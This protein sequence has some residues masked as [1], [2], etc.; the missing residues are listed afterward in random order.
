[1]DTCI[2]WHGTF[3]RRIIK[4]RN[5]YVA[6]AINPDVVV[7]VGEKLN[8]RCQQNFNSK[9]TWYKND[10]TLHKS[11]SRIRITKQFLKFKS[12]EMEDTAVYSCK[13]ESN[14][15]IHW[16]NVTVRVENLQNDGFQNEGEDKSAMNILR[17]EDGNNDLEMETRS[18]LSDNSHTRILINP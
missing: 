1:M 6:D 16:R 10:E 17:S 4:C 5:V 11:T 2:R 7:S 18:E 3:I 12:V 8:L 9:T 15:T 13:L 14:E